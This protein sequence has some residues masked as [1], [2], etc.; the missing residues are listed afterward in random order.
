MTLPPF[1][2]A[3]NDSGLESPIA[4]AT[5]RLKL[6]ALLSCRNTQPTEMLT[7]LGGQSRQQLARR[8]FSSERR[9]LSGP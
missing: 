6:A 5:Q 9:G 4:R 3:R 1:I 8:H 2:S 7:R